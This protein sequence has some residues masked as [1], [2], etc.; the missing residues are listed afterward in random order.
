M[1]HEAGDIT[2]NVCQEVSNVVNPFE[3]LN[4]SLESIVMRQMSH[5]RA[6][7][8]CSQCLV[9]RSFGLDVEVAQLGWSG[10]VRWARFGG[11]GRG[12]VGFAGAKE[13]EDTEVRTNS[14]LGS[15][16]HGSTSGRRKE[17]EREREREREQKHLVIE[18]S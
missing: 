2:S 11:G 15:L 1:K 10:R 13:G 18:F 4:P 7:H 3:Y 6:P 8:K 17:K 9:V 5:V 16:R 14:T 12:F